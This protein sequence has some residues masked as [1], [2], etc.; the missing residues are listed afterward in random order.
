MFNVGSYVADFGS[1]IV[2]GYQTGTAD[3]GLPA[4]AGLARS[5]IPPGTAATRDFSSLSPQIPQFIADACVGCMACVSACPDTAILATA[6]PREG[7]NCAI[8][9]FA[10]RSSE[11]ASS[12]VQLHAQFVETQK[13]ATVPER[14]GLE[15]ALFGIFVDPTNCKGCAECVEVCAHLGHN[16]LRMVDKGPATANAPSTIDEYRSLFSF[17]ERCHPH[18]PN[19]ATTRHSRT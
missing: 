7:L 13:Y 3:R 17:S 11:P 8:K 4:D 10:A 9:E 2:P 12:E 6:Q 14:K 19:T 18:L 5:I 16:A 1:T 15:P